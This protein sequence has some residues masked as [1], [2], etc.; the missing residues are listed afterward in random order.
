M[1]PEVPI[2][3]ATT[4]IKTYYQNGNVSAII[5]LYR[6]LYNG[7]FISYYSSGSKLREATFKLDEIDGYEKDFYPNNR[8]RELINYSSGDRNGLYELYYE[9]GKKQKTGNY[10]MDNEEGEWK[11]FNNDGSVKETITYRNGVTHDI[12]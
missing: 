9:N 5:P 8:L 2:T 4:E 10:F 1:I 7:K 6:G 3:D 12:K 11:V